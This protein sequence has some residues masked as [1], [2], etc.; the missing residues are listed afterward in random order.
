MS[1]NKI[2]VV[3]IGASLYDIIFAAD[4]YPEEDTK[5]NV[6]NVLF[7]CGGPCATA[8]AAM[9]RLGVKSA[10]VGAIAD[11]GYAEAMK[12]E[13]AEF[14]VDCSATVVKRGAKSPFSVI[15]TAADKG[16]RTIVW[17][18]GTLPTTTEDEVP[19][20]LIKNAKIL[21]LDG[22]HLEGALAAAKFARENGVKVSIDAGKLYPGVRE[23]VKYVDYF[24]AA[25]SF[26]REYAG[27][28][29]LRE[30][31]KK[32][33]AENSPEVVVVTCGKR[34]GFWY[35]GKSF[36]D[37]PIYDVP[38]VD[39]TGCGD[40]FHGAFVTAMLRGFDYPKACRFS[41][42][43]SSMKCTKPGGRAGIPTYDEAT[44]FLAGFGEKI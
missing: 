35:D 8:L 28:D 37:Y 17:N 2:D 34:G 3:G 29:D 14:G 10:Y 38:V 19:Y 36:G 24:V 15:I 5:V 39:S 6:G 12:A 41:S 16:T 7:R 42:G 18:R 11:D 40:V 22:N 30:A 4:T 31:A 1:E 26:A 13:F 43:V 44:A 25:E 23:L 27:T 21:H 33:F 9:G 20:D 32:M